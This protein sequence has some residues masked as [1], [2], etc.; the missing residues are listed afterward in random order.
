MEKRWYRM[1]VKLNELTKSDQIG[2]KLDQMCVGAPSEITHH[3]GHWWHWNYRSTFLCLFSDSHWFSK[4]HH[5]HSLCVK[6]KSGGCLFLNQTPVNQNGKS[7]GA[8]S[9]IAHRSGIFR[10]WDLDSRIVLASRLPN[11]FAKNKSEVRFFVRHSACH[12]F[13]WLRIFIISTIY[14]IK[15]GLQNGTKCA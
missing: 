1:C 9:G 10:H 12:L 15:K 14:N 8:Q 13:N 7:A 11:K 6:Q 2:T 4:V 5:K 3:S